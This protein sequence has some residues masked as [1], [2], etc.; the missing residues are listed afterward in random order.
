MK[1]LDPALLTLAHD[2][3]KAYRTTFDVLYHREAGNP[4]EIWQV[5]HTLLDLWARHDGGPPA[6]PWLTGIMDDYSTPGV[7]NTPAP[8]AHD[9]RQ[10]RSA[11]RAIRIEA[12]ERKHRVHLDTV[13][14]QEKA[15]EDERQ[16]RLFVELD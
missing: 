1:H 2:G 4:S 3:T 7:G 16:R 10:L 6:R 5:D 15:A 13:L 9:I 12:R 8:V 11:V 14:K